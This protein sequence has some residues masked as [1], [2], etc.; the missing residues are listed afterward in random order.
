MAAFPPSLP[1]LGR[2]VGP[3]KCLAAEDSEHSA[4][5][6]PAQRVSS[7]GTIFFST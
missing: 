1:L 2:W 4:L 5:Y 7:D 3:G 6:E